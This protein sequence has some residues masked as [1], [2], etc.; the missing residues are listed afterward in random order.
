L[1]CQIQTKRR[2]VKLGS[3]PVSQLAI[4]MGSAREVVA[5]VALFVVLAC[6]L[7][8]KRQMQC[9]LLGCEFK[10]NSEFR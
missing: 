4:A 8:D 5:F 10:A 3:L 1:Y 7:N 9:F 6:Y 2:L